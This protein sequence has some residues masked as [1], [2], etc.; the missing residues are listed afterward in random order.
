MKDYLHPLSDFKIIENEE[1][2]LVETM[3]SWGAASLC[4][5]TLKFGSEKQKQNAFKFCIGLGLSI[6]QIIQLLEQ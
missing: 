2:E 1:G 6:P 3:N 5:S 4:W